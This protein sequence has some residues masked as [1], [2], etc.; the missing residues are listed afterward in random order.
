MVTFFYDPVGV[1]VILTEHKNSAFEAA[2][3]VP[4]HVT[5]VI[6][7]KGTGLTNDNN[8]TPVLLARAGNID[9]L[10]KFAK[11]LPRSSKC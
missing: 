8:V 7:K 6:G 4:G 3:T 5:T 1:N 10:V 2:S 9:L 11:L